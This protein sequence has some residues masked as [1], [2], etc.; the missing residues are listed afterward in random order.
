MLGRLARRY[1]DVCY[2]LRQRYLC[3]FL[4]AGAY[5]KTNGPSPQAYAETN[6]VS[7]IP[8]PD[9]YPGPDY[10]STV[11]APNDRKKSSSSKVKSSILPGFLR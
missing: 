8:K 4:L 9:G 7:A 11:P 2:V 10:S 1:G 3:T 6:N 5:A